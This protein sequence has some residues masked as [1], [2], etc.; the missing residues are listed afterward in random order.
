MSGYRAASRRGALLLAGIALAAAPAYALGVTALT[1]IERGR[2]QVRE[3][4]SAI[5]PA[6]LCIGD[7]A[8]L[9]QFEH[10][11]APCQAEIVQDGATAAT[12]Q[13]SCPGRGFGHTQLRV[14]TPRLVRLDTQGLSDGRPFSYRLE[15]RR[16]GRC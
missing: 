15:A 2:W 5:A 12:V 10:R 8:A 1:K 9:V 14:Q 11:S 6:S 3:L 4:D 13:Y 7:T 16:V